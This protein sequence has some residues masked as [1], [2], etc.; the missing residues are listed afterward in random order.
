MSEGRGSVLHFQKTALFP[1]ALLNDFRLHA[2]SCFLSLGLQKPALL[3]PLGSIF[4]Q[5]LVS[6]PVTQDI[7]ACLRSH[8][9][10]TFFC[11]VIYR[12]KTSVTTFQVQ[13]INRSVYNLLTIFRLFCRGQSAVSVRFVHGEGGSMPSHRPRVVQSVGT[14][15]GA[16]RKY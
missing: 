10:L 6:G 5:F 2:S 11:V 12:E 15:P 7:C 8:S 14:S 13:Y 16:R 4:T 1:L 9:L 3:P